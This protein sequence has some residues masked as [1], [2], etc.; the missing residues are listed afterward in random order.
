[1]SG[2]R[3][4]RRRLANV[5]IGCGFAAGL[6]LATRPVWHPLVFG[7]QP[8]FEAVLAFSARCLPF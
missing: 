7:L 6:V 1:M 2:V 4:R 8:G 3:P 5:L